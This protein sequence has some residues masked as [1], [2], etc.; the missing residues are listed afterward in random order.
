MKHMSAAA[1]E[2]LCPVRNPNR[3]LP[4]FSCC[5]SSIADQQ[6]D[7]RVPRI[8]WDSSASRIGKEIAPVSRIL[9]LSINSLF[10]S[11][12][13]AALFIYLKLFRLISWASICFIINSSKNFSPARLD[14]L[15]LRSPRNPISRFSL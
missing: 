9:N 10:I 1:L 6:Q 8:F 15:F 3:V 13:S 11:T 14:F 5:W 7:K 12:T 2:S 4:R